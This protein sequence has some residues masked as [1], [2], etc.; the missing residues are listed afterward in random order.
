MFRE[1]GF[2]SLM[3]RRSIVMLTT[4]PVLN[5]KHL[6]LPFHLLRKQ[7]RAPAASASR[8]CPRPAIPQAASPAMEIPTP[9]T[10]RLS[11]HD[12]MKMEKIHRYYAVKSGQIAV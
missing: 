12:Q 6:S 2:R 4:L 8:L 9:P 11:D 7:L 10:A 3:F 1:K 5:K